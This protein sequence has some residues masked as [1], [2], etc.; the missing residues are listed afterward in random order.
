MGEPAVE[1]SF[2]ND[3]INIIFLYNRVKGV[4]QDKINK[5]SKDLH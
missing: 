1:V 5:T 3:K 2:D 4:I